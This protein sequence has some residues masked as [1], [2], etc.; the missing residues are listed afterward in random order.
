[1]MSSVPANTFSENSKS[2]EFVNDKSRLNFQPSE[3]IKPFFVLPEIL[4]VGD[5]KSTKA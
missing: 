2:L 3:Q 5:A 4:S 1:M